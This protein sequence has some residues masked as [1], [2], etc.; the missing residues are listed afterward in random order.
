MWAQQFVSHKDQSERWHDK[1]SLTFLSNV[2]VSFLLGDITNNM[3]VYAALKLTKYRSVGYQIS[4]CLNWTET[5][6]DIPA[7][8]CNLLS[9]ANKVSSLRLTTGSQMASLHFCSIIIV[10]VLASSLF[11]AWDKDKC[12]IHCYKKH[13]KTMAIFWQLGRQNTTVK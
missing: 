3:C 4:V 5:K 2:M 12:F 7:D 8:S 10:F 11:N 1:Y 9:V 6:P 13:R